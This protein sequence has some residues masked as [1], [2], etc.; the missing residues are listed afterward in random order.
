MSTQWLPNPKFRYQPATRP[1]SAD[2]TV[3]ID[4]LPL[5][6]EAEGNSFS[7]DLESIIPKRSTLLTI[8]HTIKLLPL[9]FVPSA[10]VGT[11]ISPLL[12]SRQLT[13]VLCS[14]IFKKDCG[15]GGIDLTD[16]YEP[17]QQGSCL[18]LTYYAVRDNSSDDCCKIVNVFVGDGGTSTDI[19]RYTSMQ[20]STYTIESRTRNLMVTT[21]S[22]SSFSTRLESNP[23]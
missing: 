5:R 8:M 3:S 4:A 12:S 7:V 17:Q 11:N 10:V 15:E 1:H 16:T 18:P 23:W 20:T 13:K 6:D 2:A 19:D 9:G 21:S 22:F 14:K